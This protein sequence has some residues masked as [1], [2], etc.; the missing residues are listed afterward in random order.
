MN[1]DE[2]YRLFIAL[3]VPEEVKK[4]LQRAQ[5]EL[6]GRLQKHTV[7]WAPP[8]QMHLTLKF[9][10]NVAS[11]RID[12]LVASLR[13]ACDG[14]APLELSAAGIGFFPNAQRPRVIW[15]GI[16]NENNRLEHLQQ[17][18]AASTGTF[19]TVSDEKAFA[20]HLTIARIKERNAS[21]ARALGVGAA[22]MNGREFGRWTAASVEIIRS[23][24]G[25]AGNRY[26]RIAEV[27][28]SH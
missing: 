10:G 14:V 19:T 21:D 16:L 3:A 18:V 15:A 20:A 9:L 24:L 7:R 27:A 11:N 8:A 1:G 5:S 28:L 13:S 12:E 6:R 23:K 26:S 22:E 2:T 25:P 17:K 4:E